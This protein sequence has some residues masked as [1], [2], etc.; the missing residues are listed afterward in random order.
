MYEVRKDWMGKKRNMSALE[1]KVDALL[2]FCTAESEEARSRFQQSL[3]QFMQEDGADALGFRPDPIDRALSDLGIP[4]HL[5]G[6]GYLQTA[7]VLA[8]EDS[9]MIHN[10]TCCLYPS[11]A[12]RHDT[13]PQL[14]ERSIRHA[15]E[16]GWT[17]CDLRMQERYFGG[18]VDP[19]RC[20]PTNTE[21]I[22]RIAN[23]IRSQIV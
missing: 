11:V 21:F 8:L 18:K 7:I 17:R 3:Q 9:E 15:I 20:K 12:R 19:D 23:V 1:R 13:R 22:A 10:V 6:Y 16:C 2:Q 4:D 14:V 5:L